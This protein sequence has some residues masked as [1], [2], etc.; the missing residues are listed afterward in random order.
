M[1][2]FQFALCTNWSGMS[3]HG[4]LSPFSNCPPGKLPPCSVHQRDQRGNKFTPRGTHCHMRLHLP[5][6]TIIEMCAH[7]ETFFSICHSDY[8]LYIWFWFGTK[9]GKCFRER[10]F[11]VSCNQKLLLPIVL[12][13]T[14]KW[15]LLVWINPIWFSYIVYR[16]WR[17]SIDCKKNTDFYRANLASNLD[18]WI[19]IELH[20]WI[21]VRKRE[22]SVAWIINFNLT[23]SGHTHSV[24]KA[25]GFRPQ[26]HSPQVTKS[27]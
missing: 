2:V 8:R 14:A 26:V 3:N 19:A 21:E 7:Q 23:R 24:R 10:S 9:D 5:P 18:I 16:R 20:D 12:D 1:V 27:A 15:Q 13:K 11:C 22:L 4:S 17:D 6:L 25:W